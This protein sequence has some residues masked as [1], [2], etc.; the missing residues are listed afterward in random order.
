[1]DLCHEAVVGEDPVEAL[2][3]CG[4]AGVRVGKVQVS[5][6]LELRRSARGLELSELLAFDEPRYLHQ[7]S[8]FETGSARPLVRALDLGALR[9]P[10]EDWQK[11]DRIESH[12]HVPVFWDAESA[13]GSTRTEVERVLRAIARDD[14]VPLLEVETYTWGVLPRERFP[15]A[16]DPDWIA[17]GIA[18]EIGFVRGILSQ[19]A[20]RAPTGDV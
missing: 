2:R 5:C 16:A 17:E 13:V 14:A 18:R 15:E 8:G 11:C 10:T 9:E 1:V 4:T 19:E 20:R 12:F 7:T 6:A 3:S